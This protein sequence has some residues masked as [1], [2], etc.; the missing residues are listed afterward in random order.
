MAAPSS[1]VPHAAF[2]AA[3]LPKLAADPR[4]VGVAAGGSYVTGALDEWSDLDL[5]VAVEEA[6]YDEVLAERREIA[7]R[8]GPLLVAF[9]GEHVGE[10]RLLICLYGPPP[11]HVDLKFVRIE[12][13]A[14]R[15]EDPVVLWE[16]A[17]RLSA[18]FTGA[19]ARYPQ[20]DVQ[21]I[22]DRFWVVVHYVATKVGRG[23]LLEA[24]DA[25]GFVRHF[26]LGPLALACRGARPT[27]VRKLEHA[28]PDLAAEIARTVASCDVRSCLTA[29]ALSVELYRTL[30]AGL[31]AAGPRRHASAEEQ[32][33]AYV[34]D[35]ASRLFPLPDL[36]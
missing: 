7:A 30:R 11:L 19:P 33:V 27:G 23:E 16:D 32:V 5:V 36:R 1:P 24:V 29:L 12:D 20:P 10:P 22:E 13:A 14:Q 3:A 21:A 9:T 6:P 31:G 18:Q 35:L 25:L 15:I 2:L 26:A 28:A 8:L 34:H 4:V 17:G